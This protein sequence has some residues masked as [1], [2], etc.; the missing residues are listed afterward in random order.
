MFNKH[1]RK[2]YHTESDRIVSTFTNATF[3]YVN[4]DCIS[5][6]L[7][8]LRYFFAPA[9]NFAAYKVCYLPI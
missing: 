6:G 3:S 8:M 1:I 9:F 2:L 7:I 4:S 5:L